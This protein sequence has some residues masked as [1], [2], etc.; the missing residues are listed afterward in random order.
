MFQIA[1][2]PGPNY[3]LDM[4]MEK[5]DDKKQKVRQQFFV[6][7]TWTPRKTSMPV[8]FGGQDP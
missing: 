8:K 3:V 2:A 1:S 6:P 4:E 7:V 5:F